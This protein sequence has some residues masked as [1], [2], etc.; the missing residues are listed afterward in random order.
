VPHDALDSS[1]AAGLRFVVMASLPPSAI[2]ERLRD[3]TQIL[4]TTS[5]KGAPRHRT[6][7]ATVEWSYRLL[8]DESQRLLRYLSVFATVSPSTPPRG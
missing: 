8:D 1:V 2:A 3:S 4:K 5:G 7:E 6:L